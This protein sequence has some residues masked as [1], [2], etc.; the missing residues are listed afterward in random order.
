MKKIILRLLP[1]VIILA[2][3]AALVVFV[4]I[5]IYSQTEE[6]TLIEPDIL[7]YEGDNKAIVMENDEMLFEM[8]AATTHFKVTEKATGRVWYSNPENADKDTVAIASGRNLMQATAVVTYT[9][10]AGSIDMDN[11]SYSIENGNFQIEQ[12]EENVVTVRY[13]IGKIEREF[14]IPTAITKERF[15]AF[16]GAVKKSTQRKISSNYS[17]YEPEKLDKRENKDEIIALYPEVLNQPLYILNEGTTENNKK[18]LEEYF[19]EAG[20]NADEHAIDQQLVA[21]SRETNGPVFNVVMNYRLTG[22]DLIVEVPYSEIRYRADYPI[23]SLTV[24]PM[25]GAMDASQEGFIFVPEGGGAIIRYNNGKLKQN[26]YYANVYGWNYS[27]YRNEVINETRSAYPV[28]GM[29]NNGSSFLCMIEGASSY[30]SIQADISMRNNSYNWARAKYTM[31]HCDQYNVSSKTSTLVFMYEKELPQDTIIQRYR[32]ID[33]DS[34][35]DMA[36]AYGEYLRENEL[37]SEAKASEEMPVSVELV[38]AIDKTVVKFGLPIDSVVAVTTFSEA[39]A[40]IQEIKDAGVN[41]LNIRMSGWMN[42]G[43]KQQ[44]L[45]KVKVLKELGGQ[46]AMEQLIAAAKEMGVSLYFDGITCFAYDSGV[47]EGFNAFSDAARYATREQVRIYPYDQITYLSDD[48]YEPF[49]LVKPAYAKEGT[50]NLIAA[51]AKSG[52]YGVAFRD[53]GYLLSGDYNPKDTVTREEVKALNIQSME[54]AKAAGQKVMIRAGNDYAVPYADIIT[55]VDLTGTKY[56]ILDQMV[57]FY[58]IA[59]HGMKDYTGESLNISGDYVQ[60]FLR[61]VEYGAGLNFTFMAE[62]GRVL[63]DTRHS[64]LFG[65]SYEA[66]KEEM[67]AM[68][69][70][71][72]QEM[73]GLNQQRIVSHEMLTEDVA[74]TGYEDGTKVYVNYSADVYTNGGVTVDAR[75][76]TV[77]R[78]E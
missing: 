38:G 63:Q 1:S 7:F 75:S 56:S 44:V 10:S 77:E 70:K 62:D 46:K 8:D 25:F 65:A 36:N 76:Y 43:V 19:Q 64:T 17:L 4:G 67:L 72:Q 50:D 12:P 30:A 39:E 3:L 9:N 57:P 33:S 42:G 49:Y 52:A 23:T 6:S 48:F 59:V 35:V 18:K 24:L 78:G 69:S 58:Q 32:F 60:E 11:Y 15:E 31:L 21:G 73:E 14:M 22:K 71:Y 28:F 29:T 54:D 13:A 66:W 34:Y 16:L 20:Y 51:L 2:L 37:M 55:D 53:I 74:V 40:I 5:P 45:S 47:L 61:C 41:N 26:A 27:T 68:V